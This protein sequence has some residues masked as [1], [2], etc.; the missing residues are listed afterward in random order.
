[1]KTLFSNKTLIAL[2]IATGIFIVRF[3]PHPINCTP[4]G[5]LSL[6]AGTL[7]PPLWATLTI[8]SA[9]FL[10]DCFCGFHSTMPFVYVGFLIATIFGHA[11]KTKQT[12]LR[13]FC[14]S[15]SSSLVFFFI[16]NF[17]SWLVSGMYAH[18]I[19]GLIQCY[20]YAIP[21]AQNSTDQIGSLVGATILSDLFF[22]VII[23]TTYFKLNTPRLFYYFK[24]IRNN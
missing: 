23:F 5:A 21:F 24:Y 20:F 13:L 11:L 1:M 14:A 9:L 2:A 15:I 16:T 7:F 3:I 17:G 22:T 18:T 8:L 12:Y 19:S 6:F 10:G 4:I